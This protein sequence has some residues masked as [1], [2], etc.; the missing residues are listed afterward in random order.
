MRNQILFF[1]IIF[2]SKFLF[3]SDE[4]HPALDS[5]SV[6][7][8]SLD[9][10]FDIM[11]KGMTPE[12]KAKM[13]EAMAQQKVMLNEYESLTPEQ[14]KKQNEE[15]IKNLNSPEGKEKMKKM[16]KEITPEEKEMMNLMIRNV[17]ENFK[18]I[19]PPEPERIF[20]DVS[21]AY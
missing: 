20:R 12:M 21:Q 6:T 2:I 14:Q 11:T 7:E 15:N 9:D 3:A 16:A 18:E 8:K 19:P 10:S 1:S 5:R 13:K 4:I 17:K